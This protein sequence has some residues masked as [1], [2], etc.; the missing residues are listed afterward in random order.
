MNNFFA[1]Q[2]ASRSG[3]NISRWDGITKLLNYLVRLLLDFVAAF[4]DE[5]GSK[6]IVVYKHRICIVDNN[7]SWLMTNITVLHKKFG[8]VLKR[9]LSQN[10][11]NEVP[12]GK[13]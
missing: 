11:V 6:T 8:S 9:G 1:G 2:R 4:A 3:N 12:F 10:H 5:S 13:H 7:V